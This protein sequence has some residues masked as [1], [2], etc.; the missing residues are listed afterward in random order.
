MVNFNFDHFFNFMSFFNFIHSLKFPHCERS[1]PLFPNNLLLNFAVHF[2]FEQL[3]I[4][5]FGSFL[6]F[7]ARIS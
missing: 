4:Q 2:N 1:E 5:D 7:G 6:H 3:F